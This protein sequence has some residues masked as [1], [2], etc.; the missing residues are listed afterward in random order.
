[1][2][3]HEKSTIYLLLLVHLKIQS[4]K[5]TLLATTKLS[6]HLFF[7][8]YVDEFVDD[9]KIVEFLVLKE[10]DDIVETISWIPKKGCVRLVPMNK[11]YFLIYLCLFL[12]S[13]NS[14]SS[15]KLPDTYSLNLPSGMHQR[16]GLN[17]CGVYSAAAVISIESASVPDIPL[18]KKE[19]NGRDKQGLTYP[20]GIIDELRKYGINSKIGLLGLL[21]DQGRI[22]FIKRKISH[23]QPVIILNQIPGTKVL[24]WYTVVGYDSTHIHLYDSLVQAAGNNFNTIDSN[25]NNP[26]N[27][28]ISYTDFLI[29]WGNASFGIL[30]WIIVE[31]Y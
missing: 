2:R 15:T 7:D 20:W 28:Q 13:C 5:L 30:N 10:C 12:F 19:M 23:D 6:R 11:M 26:G 27:R 17:E 8:K 18:L 21:S 29:E 3:F 16:Q 24:H 14:V 9:T 1:M 22:H 25:G 4:C 31:V